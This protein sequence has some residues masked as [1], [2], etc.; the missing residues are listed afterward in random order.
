LLE[1][2]TTGTHNHCGVLLVCV[3]SWK[4]SNDD[5]SAAA[6]GVTVG[7]LFTGVFEGVTMGVVVTVTDGVIV[8]VLLTGVIEG[9]TM[10]VVVTVTDEVVVGIDVGVPPVVPTACSKLA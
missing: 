6:D 5:G 4:Q 1:V 7:V 10:G 3:C 8:G 9:V 2:D